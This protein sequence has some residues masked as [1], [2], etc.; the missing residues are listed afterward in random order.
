MRD[1]PVA[2][3]EL[4]AEAIRAAHGSID[5]AFTGSP[6]FVH[7]ALSSRLGV[8]V[9]V[10]VETVNPIRAFKGRGTW[11]AVHG[12]A[13][14]GR[15]G[16][17]RPVVVASAGNFGQGVAYAARALG[18][19][20]VVFTSRNANRGKIA[21]M[22]ALGATV[23]EEGEDFDDARA[24]SEAY[25]AEHAAE[26]LVDGDDP[27]IATGAAT[28]ALELTDAIDAGALPPIA[29]AM[30]PVGNGALIDGVGSWFRYASPSTR[31]V[32]VQAEGADAMT[33]SFAARRPIDTE[34]ADTYADGI[35]SRIAIPRAVELMF[36]RVDAMMTVGEAALHEAQAE[37]TDAL[38]VTVEGAAAASWAG[39]LAAPPPDGTALVIV[40]GSNV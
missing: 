36:G 17:D 2:I 34:R 23:I 7:E 3:P 27:R 40:T 16:A 5:P 18:V 22:R 35:A 26:L 25:A 12:L 38:G 21:R 6:Q 11:V 20:T 4:T 31:V 29:I 32:G 15:I 9:V 19:P 8:P 13:G 1:S 30:V 10:K 39:L 14:E 24:A 37:L 28:L 33:R